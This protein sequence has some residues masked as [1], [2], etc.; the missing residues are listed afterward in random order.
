[1]KRNSNSAKKEENEKK[2]KQKSVTCNKKLLDSYQP[3]Q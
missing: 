3:S 2:Q 1:M